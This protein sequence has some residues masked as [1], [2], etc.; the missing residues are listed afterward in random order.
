MEEL[1]KLWWQ[2]EWMER[3]EIGIADLPEY[4]KHDFEIWTIGNKPLDKMEGCK[5]YRIK[6]I[7]NYDYEREDEEI[8]KMESELDSKLKKEW[9]DRYDEEMDTSYTKKKTGIG[10]KHLQKLEKIRKQRQYDWWEENREVNLQRKIDS[11]KKE[12]KKKIKENL[13]WEAYKDIEKLKEYPSIYN[14]LRNEISTKREFNDID[15]I[16]IEDKRKDVWIHIP[17]PKKI[18]EKIL[19]NSIKSY[20]KN[21]LHQSFWVDKQSYKDLVNNYT[22]ELYSIFIITDPTEKKVKLEDLKRK[23]PNIVTI[24]N[25]IKKSDVLSYFSRPSSWGYKYDDMIKDMSKNNTIYEVKF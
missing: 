19:K 7:S 3:K 21:I 8:N 14:L 4:F 17:A 12:A 2:Y 18:A 1:N 10:K 25:S 11:E 13:M 6:I 20:I 15:V 16:I 9:I 23:D 24:R 5:I 22:N